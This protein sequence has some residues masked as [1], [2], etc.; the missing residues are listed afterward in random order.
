MTMDYQHLITNFSQLTR[1]FEERL[2]DVLPKLV[3]ALAI[4]AAGF[5]LAFLLR[6]LVRRLVTGLDRVI[7][8][9][10]VKNSLRRLGMERS[11][12][13]VIGGVVYWT[14][15]IFFLTAATETLGL[16]VVT[17]WLSGIALYLPRILSGVLICFAGL[18]GGVLVRD[19]IVSAATSAG[20]AYGSALGRLAQ[21]ATLLI[22]V[23]I[24]VEQVG[25]DVDFLT[26]A[27]ITLVGIVLFGGSLAFG[28][29]ARVTVSNIL[30]VHYLQKVYAVGQQVRIG[31]WQGEIV[32]IT[33]TAVILETVEGR[34]LVPAK[35]FTEAASM[36]VTKGD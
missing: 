30:A 8:G 5:V 20:I 21:G 7:P 12:A 32:Q 23:L 2:L 14:V 33:A 10:K 22:S 6:F 26:T 15:L 17:T 34:I 31:E 4:M 24:A 16:P 28:L 13:D 36:L 1:R 11:A 19:L 9:Q 29:G 27:A 3:G 35:L 18:I 25:I